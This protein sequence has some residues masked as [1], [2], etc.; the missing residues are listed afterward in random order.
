MLFLEITIA[1]I[2][3][4]AGDVNKKIDSCRGGNKGIFGKIECSKAHAA[5]SSTRANKSC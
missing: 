5:Y 3:E 1:G 4:C 2:N